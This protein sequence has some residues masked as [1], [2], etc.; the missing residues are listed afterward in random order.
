MIVD[1]HTLTEA[2]AQSLPVQLSSVSLVLVVAL[3]WVWED[4]GSD[5]LGEKWSSVILMIRLTKGL[6]GAGKYVSITCLQDSTAS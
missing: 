6:H 4:K 3:D 2:E 1:N 5:L